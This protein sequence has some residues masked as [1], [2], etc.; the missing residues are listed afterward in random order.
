MLTQLKNLQENQTKSQLPTK[1][2]DFQKTTLKK[3]VQEAEKFKAEDEAIK[4]RIEAKNGLESY[5]ANVKNS[6]NEEKL[7]DKFTEEDKTTINTK[8]E[9]I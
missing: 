1:R 6:L 9:E 7:K 4:K 5:L 2:V 8:L 3:L